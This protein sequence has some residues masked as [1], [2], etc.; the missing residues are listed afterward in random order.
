M[1]AIYAPHLSTQGLVFR[2]LKFPTAA[3]PSGVRVGYARRKTSD[4]AR[5]STVVVRCAEHS[6]PVLNTKV[7]LKDWFGF[8]QSGGI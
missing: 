4:K 3:N 2:I 6:N 8:E 7:L 5:K 1:G